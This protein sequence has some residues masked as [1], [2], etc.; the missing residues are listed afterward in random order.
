[1]IVEARMDWWSLTVGYNLRR[2]HDTQR[3]R[4]LKNSRR[5]MDQ[6]ECIGSTQYS[7]LGRAT[8]EGASRLMVAAAVAAKTCLLMT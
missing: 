1:M 3:G 2:T 7:R 4:S 5:Q 8:S 6:L